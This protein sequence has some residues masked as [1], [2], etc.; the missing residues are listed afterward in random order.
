[1]TD[2][3]SLSDDQ[4]KA[5]Y[6]QPS[7]SS[8][9]DEQ[10]KSLYQS[11]KPKDW[12]VQ[13]GD[14]ATGGGVGLAEGVMGLAG[15]PGDVGSLI[16]SGVDAIGNKMGV[17]PDKVAAFKRAAVGVGRSS[18]FTAG[19]TNMFTTGPTSSQ[20]KNVVESFTG[21]LPQPTSEYGKI[22]KTVG[23]F[24]PNVIGGPE[25]IA[26][27]LLTRVAAPTVGS[28]VAG[29]LTEGTAAEPYAKAAGGLAALAGASSVGSRFNAAVKG[30][31]T[32]A[33]DDL[34][35]AA[36]AGYKHEDVKAIQ[37]KSEAL[38]DLATKIEKDLQFGHN[39]GF[40]SANE[41]KVFSAIDELRNPIKRDVVPG[42]VDPNTILENV[43]R[44]SMG[45]KPKALGPANIDDID[46]VRQLLGNIAKERDGSG[47]LTRQAVAANRAIGHIDDF[48]PN[49]KQT[50]LLA[51]DAAKAN[52]ILETARKNWGAAKR[53]ETVQ[54]TLANAEINAA[55]SH[56][57]AN[58][59]NAT[60]QAFKPLLKNNAAKAVGY[61]DEEI[62]AL[63]NVV[64]G[65][66]TGSAAR[67]AGN[68]LGGGGGLGMLASGAVGYEAGGAP[69]AIAAGLAGR[70]LKMVGNR[71]T[72]NAVAKLDKMLR[73]RSPE[74]LKVVA[75]NPQ[76][77]QALPP[78]QLQ[79]LR[80]L[81]LSEPALRD[82]I[83]QPVSQANAY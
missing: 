58:I 6:Q 7:L 41:P 23:E 33:V 14:I 17:E 24:V 67:A 20:I 37:I 59:Q 29:R 8:M 13:P 38:D 63:N 55:A 64:R 73:A 30:G 44:K 15:L 11:S 48:L 56:S 16:S 80:S 47:Q 82:Q 4:L 32:P 39:S 78:K 22:A 40:R 71:S 34:K 51:G 62:A 79:A 81:I 52:S 2:L 70:G 50:D 36:R 31:A 21:E 27:K 69:G 46:S 60:K 18:P 5:L 12:S 57:G 68:L 10:L 9:S 53:A 83:S 35:A 28:E 75:Q 19:P 65:T 61:N 74:A 72:F 3:S 45:E 43:F 76:L 26:T 54:T 49:L 77:A 25:A 1:M 42:E 66:W